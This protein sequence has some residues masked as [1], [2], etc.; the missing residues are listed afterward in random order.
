MVRVGVERI[1]TEPEPE[2]QPVV[3]VDIW[4]ANGASVKTDEAMQAKLAELAQETADRAT[5]ILGLRSG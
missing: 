1:H 2:K 5:E 3:K 4:I